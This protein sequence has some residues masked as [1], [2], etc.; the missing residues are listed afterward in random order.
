MANFQ[1][2]STETAQPSEQ[3]EANITVKKSAYGTDEDVQEFKEWLTSAT[4]ELPMATKHSSLV[5]SARDIICRWRA[6]MP[7]TVW[8]RI[9]K[10]NRI[11]KELNEYLPVIARVNS[12]LREHF[13][14]SSEMVTIVDLCSGYGFLSMLLSE[15]L[16]AKE[17]KRIILIDKR[18]P[19]AGKDRKDSQQQSCDHITCYDWPIRLETRKQNIK[20]GREQR[21]LT[22]RI[23]STDGV[24]VMLGV[25]LCG[26]L[27]CKAVEIFNSNENIQF[28][29]LKPCC[30]PGRRAVTQELEWTLGTHHFTAIELYAGHQQKKKFQQQKKESKGSERK[31]PEQALGDPIE[32]QTKDEA[33]PELEQSEA[34]ERQ[35]TG[36]EMRPRRRGNRTE[37]ARARRKNARKQRAAQTENAEKIGDKLQNPHKEEKAQQT[38]SGQNSHPGS[39]LLE[40]FAGHLHKGVTKDSSCT[41][42]QHMVQPHDHQNWFIFATRTPT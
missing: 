39:H 19:E 12:F 24:Y 40:I 11:L 6:L 10:D 34:T 35:A 29:T 31:A 4:K 8:L 20:K 13:A 15:M 3:K 28:L 17:I 36:T 5:E 23:F 22:E 38:N 37:E 14:N 30:L 41:L 2:T 33:S 27:S 1:G 32:S 16:D 42:E 9:F 25:H 7:K 26:A 21:Q 18:W